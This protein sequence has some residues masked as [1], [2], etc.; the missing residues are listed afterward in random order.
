MDHNDDYTACLLETKEF[1]LEKRRYWI[2]FLYFIYSY[3]I[4]KQ[5][6]VLE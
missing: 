3:F 2:L 4:F 1:K 5:S 6:N